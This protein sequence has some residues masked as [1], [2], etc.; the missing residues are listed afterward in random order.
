M[1]S[2]DYLA[3]TFLILAVLF[4]SPVRADFASSKAWFSS[5]DEQTR[6][7]IQA[8][9]ILVGAYDALA[10][11]RFGLSTFQAL[12]AYQSARGKTASGVLG[13]VEFGALQSEANVIS[14]ELG[15]QEVRDAAT[16][17][18]IYV[19]TRLVT[20]HVALTNGTHYTSPL[21]DFDLQTIRMPAEVQNFASL[22]QARNASNAVRN[23]TY[24]AMVES[25]F[26]VTG[27]SGDRYFYDR[28]YNRGDDAVGFTLTWNREVGDKGGMLAAYLASFSHPL[29]KAVTDQASGLQPGPAVELPLPSVATPPTTNNTEVPLLSS[30]GTFVVPV[31]INGALKLNFTLD[32]GAADVSIP[33]DVV[34]TLIRTGTIT[35]SDFTGTQTYVL[36]DGSAVPSQTFR[37]RSLKVGD[38]V[39]ENVAGSVASVKGSLLLGQS[40]LTHFSSWS[41]DN[42]RHVLVLS[43]MQPAGLSGQ[44]DGATDSHTPQIG[45]SPPTVAAPET[46]QS[47][48]GSVPPG[49][50]PATAT[51]LALY[52]GLD[53]YGNDI[54][55][56]R[57][58]GAVECAS[59]C[60]RVQQ[61]RAFTFNANPSIHSGPNCFIKGDINRIEAYSTAIGGLL[62]K[63]QEVVP[64]YSFDAIDPTT[65]VMTNLDFPGGN[66]SKFPYDPARTPDNCRMACIDNQAC[67]A[68][69]FVTSLRQC[70]LKR[71][72]GLMRSA[73][74][75]VSGKKR[76]LSITSSDVLNVPR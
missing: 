48:V 18:D 71:S 58:P 25:A 68:F 36:A 11:G 53:F 41:I 50:M 63:P 69:S 43:D 55:K 66:L 39:I 46:T 14:Q 5:F 24:S 40:F 6:T 52:G 70:W 74:G 23:V 75:V 3:A 4:S 56:G 62:L 15:L 76:R 21:G 38:K 19:P 42:N 12:K 7:T 13:S 54:F 17:I 72:S 73:I 64:Q 31:L 27:I 9:L 60:L 59:A 47:Q 61:C 2:R 37:I 33:A 30:G 20:E 8:D 34:L 51:R 57:T 26:T 10:D 29:E 44:V 1:N 67:E 28:Y 16:G 45:S 35:A 32:S 49:H 22:F 65:D